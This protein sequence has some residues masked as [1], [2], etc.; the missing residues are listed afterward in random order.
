MSPCLPRH[1]VIRNQG[2]RLL[3]T[4]GHKGGTVLLNMKWFWLSHWPPH[5]IIIIIIIYHIYILSLYLTTRYYSAHHLAGK[6]KPMST[7]AIG[8]N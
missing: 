8:G 7:L 5:D 3:A 6:M 2:L 1:C 4:I